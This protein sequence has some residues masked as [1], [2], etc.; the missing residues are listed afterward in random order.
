MPLSNALEARDADGR[1]NR[2]NHAYLFSGP[3]GCGKTSSARILARSLNCEHGPT[4]TPCGKCGSCLSLAPGGAGN[5]DVVELDAAS[6]NSVEDMRE[7]RDKAIY[8]PTSSRYTI[9]IID[10]AHMVSRQGFNALLKVVEEPPEHLIF[11]FA[12]TEPEKVLPTIRSRT[13]HYPFRLLA[14]KDMRGLLEGVVEQ[15]GVAIDP[16]VYPLVIAAGGGSPRDSL[17]IL[18]QLVAGAGPDGVDYELATALLGVT[19]DSLLDDAVRALSTRDAGALFGCVDRVVDS[20]LDP[21]RFAEDL[22]G[23]MRD[24]MVLAAVPDAV[25]RELIDTTPDRA[26]VLAAQSQSMPA[27][28]ITRYAEVLHEGIGEMRGATSQRLLLEVLCARM[29]LP[30]GGADVAALTRRIE[31]LE[32]GAGPVA[33]APAGRP[34][35]EP[36]DPADDAGFGEPDDAPVGGGSAADMV[37][38]WRARRAGTPGAQQ[39]QRPQSQPQQEPRP[40]PEAEPEPPRGADGPDAEALRAAKEAARKLREAA[41]V[42][43]KAERQRIA[44]EQ[45]NAARRAEGLPEEPVADLDDDDTAGAPDDSRA[46][47][48]SGLVTADPAAAETPGPA[49]EDD[50]AGERGDVA[51]A[52]PEPEPESEPEEEPLDVAKLRTTWGDIMAAVDPGHM[53]ARVLAASAVPLELDGDELTVGHHTGALANRLNAPEYSGAIAGA[54]RDVH[55]VELSVHFVVGMNRSGSR[56]RSRNATPGRGGDAGDGDSSDSPHARAAAPPEPNPA[57]EREPA[58]KQAQD[59][60]LPVWRKLA[61]QRQQIDAQHHAAEEERRKREEAAQER[62]RQEMRAKRAAQ[63]SADFGGNDHGG[64]APDAPPPPEPYDDVPPPP[65]PY[66]VAPPPPEDGGWSG[67]PV[68][69]SSPAAPVDEAEEYINAA[70]EVGSLDHRSQREVVMEMLEQELGARPM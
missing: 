41:H 55:G 54:I 15:E 34:A 11:V 13:H 64:P 4:A 51:P 32:S 3:R 7:L 61:R 17:S 29:L 14:P 66:D 62:R 18:D 53:A 43:E 50:V 68:A 9:F 27:G 63:R 49:S 58:P 10:E 35:P 5:L 37:A 67:G 24:L 46:A 6:H 33:A 36:D 12:T 65:E 20:G 52:E 47:E 25:Q 8:P 59:D 48:E 39:G 56:P 22:L 16:Q 45:E 69:S 31:A 19:D 23:R 38:A 42:Q 28:D 1:P 57:P 30:S 40:E 21:R 60:A 70:R 26:E 2:I 44:M